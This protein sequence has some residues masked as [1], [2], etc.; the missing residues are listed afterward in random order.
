MGTSERFQPS[1]MGRRSSRKK[2]L[3]YLD[4]KSE[5][6]GEIKEGEKGGNN[7]TYCFGAIPVDALPM[8]AK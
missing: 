8:T 1:S 2:M 5:V 7:E 3:T 6:N 4:E